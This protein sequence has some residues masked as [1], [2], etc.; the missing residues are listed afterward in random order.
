LLPC[1]CKWQT[2]VIGNELNARDKGHIT[3]PFPVMISASTTRIV[4]RR[5]IDISQ[6]CPPAG[7]RSNLRITTRSSVSCPP[8][9]IY[10]TLLLRSSS[11]PLPSKTIPT[12]ARVLQRGLLFLFVHWFNESCCVEGGEIG[13]EVCSMEKVTREMRL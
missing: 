2:V 12:D 8:V 9:G 11:V 6:S 1:K 13:E 5:I 4:K 3:S 10:R 7:I